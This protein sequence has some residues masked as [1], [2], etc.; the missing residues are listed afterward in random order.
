M[1]LGVRMVMAKSFERIHSANLVNF[2]IVPLVFKNA[3]DY[4]AIHAGDA[5]SVSGLVGQVRGGGDIT[6]EIAG[7]KYQFTLLASGR[8]R[9]I[10]IQGG[11]LNFT[12]K[13]IS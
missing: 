4:D 10:L 7:K 3:G 5:F 1:Y 6:V 13:S 2:G 12:K 8:Q 9:E 11:L